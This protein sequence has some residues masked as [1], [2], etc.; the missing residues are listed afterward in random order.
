MKYDILLKEDNPFFNVSEKRFKEIDCYIPLK[1]K[2]KLIKNISYEDFIIF[3]NKV[4]LSRKM[5]MIA[6]EK[7]E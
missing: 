2:I 3:L 6:G 5:T 1:E 4:Y 7:N